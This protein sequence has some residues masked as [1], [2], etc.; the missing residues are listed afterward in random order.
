MPSKHRKA[1]DLHGD[2]PGSAADALMLI[3]VI[4]DLIFQRTT[5][6]SVKRLS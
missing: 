1:S 3:D 2:V 4:N 5:E 6:L